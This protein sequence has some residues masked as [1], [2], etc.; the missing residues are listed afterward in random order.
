VSIS[1]GKEKAVIFTDDREGLLKSVERSGQRLSATE[2]IDQ[3]AREA[4]EAREGRMRWM[5]RRAR[6]AMNEAADAAK[7][8]A[9]ETAR[10][11][12]D[13]TRTWAERIG[14]ERRNRPRGYVPGR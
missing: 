2:L 13:S 10:Q 12:R 9:R 5:A 6:I 7:E 8:K 14:Q 4:A 11:V 3:R 1:R